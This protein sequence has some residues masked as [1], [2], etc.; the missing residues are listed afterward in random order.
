M[1][2]RSS[3]RSILNVVDNSLIIA[4]STDAAERGTESFVGDTSV[5]LDVWRADGM[6]VGEN[7]TA[8]G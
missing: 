3:D 7:R 6:A 2:K 5:Q 1:G 8:R 4:K